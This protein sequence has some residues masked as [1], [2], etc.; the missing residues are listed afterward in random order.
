MKNKKI[1]SG[2]YVTTVDNFFLNVPPKI[3][4]YVTGLNLNFTFLN[5]HWALQ[6]SYSVMPDSL[7]PHRLQHARPPCP[8]PTLRAC[9]NSCPS[10]RWMDI[11]PS[12]PLLSPSPPA[13]NLSQHQGLFQWVSFSHQVA[14]VLELQ[15]QHQSFQWLFRTNFLYDSVQFP[16]QL[17][18]YQRLILWRNCLSI[19]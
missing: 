2:R 19:F 14:K 13:F 6:F 5:Y 17:G 4:K 9:S 3:S 10:S 12:N 8:S 7:Q 1:R 11:Q 15:L 18:S 16:L